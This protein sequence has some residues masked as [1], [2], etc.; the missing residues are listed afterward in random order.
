[1]KNSPVSAQTSTSQWDKINICPYTNNKRLHVWKQS[2]GSPLPAAL[3]SQQ[4]NSTAPALLMVFCGTQ[5]WNGVT[6]NLA[7]T[8]TYST[9]ASGH[10]TLNYPLCFTILQNSVR[11][12]FPLTNFIPNK[13][14]S[15][16]LDWKVFFFFFCYTICFIIFLNLPLR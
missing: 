1:M 2:L 11:V 12:F 5:W 13:I 7:Y 8:H 6:S 10:K 9:T 15:V 3:V 14:K 4:A 16:Q